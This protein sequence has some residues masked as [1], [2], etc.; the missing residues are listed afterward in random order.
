MTAV[1]HNATQDRW[2]FRSEPAWSCLNNLAAQKAQHLGGTLVC[3]V[4]PFVC[5]VSQTIENQPMN[6]KR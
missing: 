4:S 3:I 2:G 1:N 6:P 5:I